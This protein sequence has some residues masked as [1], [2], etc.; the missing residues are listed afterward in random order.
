MGKLDRAQKR[1]IKKQK[2][3]ETKMINVQNHLKK[4]DAAFNAPKILKWSEHKESDTKKSSGVAPLHIGSINFDTFIFEG[5]AAER[6]KARRTTEDNITL[7][8]KM[9]DAM[10]KIAVNTKKTTDQDTEIKKTKKVGLEAKL[11]KAAKLSFDAKA[12]DFMDSIWDK[13]T[14]FLLKASAAALLFAPMVITA[15]KA[16]GWGGKWLLK[17][18]AAPAILASKMLGLLLKGAKGAFGMGVTAVTAVAKGVKGV[19]D[20]AKYAAKFPKQAFMNVMELGK[21]M[22][23][24]GVKS[25]W[26]A[27]KSINNMPAKIWRNGGWIGKLGVLSVAGAGIYLVAGALGVSNQQW[28]DAGET[29]KDWF[30]TSKFAEVISNWWSSWNMKAISKES[31]TKVINWWELVQK[32]GIWAGIKSTKDGIISLYKGFWGKSYEMFQEMTSSKEPFAY[33]GSKLW[34]QIINT[35]GNISMFIGKA[36]NAIWELIKLK[37]IDLSPSAAEFL[38]IVSK[39]T[40]KSVKVQNDFRT[41]FGYTV[42]REVAG[43]LIG[44]AATYAEVEAEIK[45][46]NESRRKQIGIIDNYFLKH[47]GCPAFWVVGTQRQAGHHNNWKFFVAQVGTGRSAYYVDKKTAYTQAAKLEKIKADRQ[48]ETRRR[49]LQ[50]KLDKSV[51]TAY[52]QAAKLE[53]KIGKLPENVSKAA[54]SVLN[55][56]EPATSQSSL[57]GMLGKIAGAVRLVESSNKY[58]IAKNHGDG[59]GVTVGAYQFTSNAGWVQKLTLIAKNMGVPGATSQLRE[60]RGKTPGPGYIGWFKKYGNTKEFQ[61][62]QNKAFELFFYNPGKKLAAKYGIS[63]PVMIGHIIDHDHNTGSRAENMIKKLKDK[64]VEGISIARK[65]DYTAI[66]NA[67]SSKKQYLKGWYKRV[68]KFSKAMGSGVIV[69]SPSLGSDILS[70]SSLG[71]LI[72]GDIIKNVLGASLAPI[73]GALGQ[74]FGISMTDSLSAG[75]PKSSGESVEGPISTDTTDMGNCKI[76][77][78]S[79]DNVKPEVI[80]KLKKFCAYAGTEMYVN[81]AYRSPAYNTSIGGAKNSYHMKGMALDIHWPKSSNSSKASFLSAALKAGFTGIGIYPN[82]IHVDIGPAREWGDSSYGGVPPWAQSLIN[83]LRKGS[84]SKA[85]FSSNKSSITTP[86]GA[87]YIPSLGGLVLNGGQAMGI[88]QENNKLL[89]ADLASIRNS[90]NA[91]QKGQHSAQEGDLVG[92][93]PISEIQ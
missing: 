37:I 3:Q 78:K 73:M 52:T 35:A 10:E 69:P 42:T 84:G 13:L 34:E 41:P 67:N 33:L 51:K 76:R 25:V 93:I 39:E 12:G 46:G 71:S 87:V 61:A 15:L 57:S 75:I 68:D 53:K 11:T 82:F 21:K 18:A 74:A 45:K 38:G 80:Q 66:A 83:T 56:P 43:K 32:E 7:A 63:N 4:V 59:G 23:V 26:S 60:F 79:L 19:W 89:G 92:I 48:E 55:K 54:S 16:L 27:L 29:I 85:I 31:F 49:K 9:V 8:G 77:G 6:D 20:I 72:T 24:G 86:Q 40:I 5:T 28:K 64:T 36:E 14:D 81:S 22:I 2:A 47:Y 30:V 62:A 65:D 50:P 17:F 58:D 1:A 88:I 91:L 44:Y 90:V 70:M